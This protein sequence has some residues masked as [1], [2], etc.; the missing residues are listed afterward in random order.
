MTNI[1]KPA[2][3]HTP[4][5]SLLVMVVA[6]VMLAVVPAALAAA[7]RGGRPVAV[8]GIADEEAGRFAA[9]GAAGGTVLAS[10]N[11]RITVV[12]PDGEGFAERMRGHG[13]WIILDAAAVP[14]CLPSSLERRT[15]T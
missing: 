13:Y 1:S 7:P 5:R 2:P 11:S 14:G 9:I 10:I 12:V 4:I 8:I 3:R 6:T 15:S